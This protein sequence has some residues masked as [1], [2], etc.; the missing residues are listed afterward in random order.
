MAVLVSL[1]AT[2]EAAGLTLRPATTAPAVDLNMPAEQRQTLL[3][4]LLARYCKG[5]Q[6]C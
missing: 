5:T 4:K 2:V 1:V 6:L 3:Q